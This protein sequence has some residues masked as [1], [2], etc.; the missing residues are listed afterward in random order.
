MLAVNGK[1][2]CRLG[3]TLET[4]FSG[5]SARCQFNELTADNRYSICTS[6]KS[7]KIELAIT[8]ELSTETKGLIDN[9]QFEKPAAFI[10]AGNW[11]T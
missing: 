8:Y 11:S 1:H 10:V 4:L 7:A 9:N 5:W 2:F 6:K 3:L